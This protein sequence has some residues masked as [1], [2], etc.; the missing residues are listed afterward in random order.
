MKLRS[1][2]ALVAGSVVVHLAVACGSQAIEAGPSAS[3]SGAVV[4]AV[5]DVIADVPS[6]E[7]APDGGSGP[8]V[9]TLTCDK[10]TDVGGTKFY[11]AEQLFPGRT[12]VQLT[13]VRVM[14]CYKAGSP[15]TAGYP[16]GYTCSFGGGLVRDGA[17][18][19]TCG[20][21]PSVIASIQIIDG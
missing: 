21:D 4:D 8:T 2:L 16:V 18:A 17:I 12:A 5:M 15:S 6:A 14:Y 11:Y 20:S 9:T 19:V 13:S 3:D 7:A 10:F 1:I